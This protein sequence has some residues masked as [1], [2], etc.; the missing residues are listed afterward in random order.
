M[1]DIDDLLTARER[2]R[3]KVHETPVYT[4]RLLNEHS[5]AELFF[6]CENLQKVGAFKARGACNAVFSLTETEVAQGV[7]TH[8]SGN[9]AAA[10]AMAARLR[11]AQAHIVMPAM[12]RR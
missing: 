12:H 3:T 10:L 6:K 5:A 11:G 8:S 4:S 1:P 9:H 7:A 2:I